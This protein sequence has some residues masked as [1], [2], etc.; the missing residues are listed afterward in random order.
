MAKFRHKIG[1]YAFKNQF[2][3]EA[4]VTTIEMR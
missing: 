2:D 3:T 4:N 1:I